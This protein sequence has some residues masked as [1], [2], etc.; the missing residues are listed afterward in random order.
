MYKYRS[1]E[2]AKL[3]IATANEKKLSINMTKTQ[4]LLYIAYGIHLA[5]RDVRLT[6]EHPQA[7]PYGPVF[8]T[9]RKRLLKEDLYSITKDDA[10]LREISQDEDM[11]ALVELVFKHFG[12]WSAQTLTIWSHKDGSPWQRTVSSEGFDWGEQI[13]DSYIKPYFQRMIR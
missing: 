8:P 2:V 9:T 10:E 7:W 13:P 4:K 6:D 3:I 5:V 12:M 1:T 11:T